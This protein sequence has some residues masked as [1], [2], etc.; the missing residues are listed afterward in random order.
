MLV[1]LL[2][3]VCTEKCNPIAA[4]HC[5]NE[6][7]IKGLESYPL[8][9]NGMETMKLFEPNPFFWFIQQTRDEGRDRRAMLGE[10]AFDV[11]D[12]M[13]RRRFTQRYA[14]DEGINE[15]FGPYCKCVMLSSS[16]SQMN[17]TECYGFSKYVILDSV[18]QSRTY[19]CRS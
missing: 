12:I 2:R 10:C 16:F 18:A 19:I 4:G 1:T 9:D 3:F 8:P 17:H 13:G 5:F 7:A 6:Y 11:S 14:E 15:I